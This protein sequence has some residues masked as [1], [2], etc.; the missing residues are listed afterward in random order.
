VSVDPAALIGWPGPDEGPLGA[1]GAAPVVG[2]EWD[3]AAAAIR[4]AEQEIGRLWQA[5]I[6]GEHSTDLQRLADVSHALS[7]AS[8]LLGDPGTLA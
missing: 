3:Q 8:R 7:R 5:S 6:S 1:A 4:L 2:P